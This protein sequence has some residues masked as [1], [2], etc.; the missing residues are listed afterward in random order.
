VLATRAPSLEIRDDP[1][2][3]ERLFEAWPGHEL[4]ERPE[5][6]DLVGRVYPSQRMMSG[7][8]YLTYMATR[9]QCRMMPEP[10][11]HRLFAALTEVFDRPVP[12]TVETVLYLARVVPA[13]TSGAAT[14]RA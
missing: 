4:A 14:D 7:A 3:A 13:E 6:T 10:D 11:R 8:D 12:L 9:S 2:D 5:F 1:V